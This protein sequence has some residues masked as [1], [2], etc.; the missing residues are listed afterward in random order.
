MLDDTLTT[1]FILRAPF[2]SL[3]QSHSVIASLRAVN[4]R[5]A[6]FSCRRIRD[7]YSGTVIRENGSL[8][9]RL[10][11]ARGSADERDCSGHFAD[12]DPSELAAAAGRDGE[13]K[14][15]LLQATLRRVRK[16]RLGGDRRET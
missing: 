6:L 4:V 2:I 11:S 15:R 3:P 9:R 1:P 16:R 8:I 13:W 5:R 14:D 7:R 10:F 12:R